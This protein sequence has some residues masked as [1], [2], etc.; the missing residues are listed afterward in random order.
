[1]LKPGGKEVV[2]ANSTLNLLP[3]TCVLKRC[4]SINLNIFGNNKSSD[5]QIIID[6]PLFRVGAQVL[7]YSS[8]IIGASKSANC[9]EDL[10]WIDQPVNG[11]RE[12]SCGAPF[13]LPAVKIKNVK[14]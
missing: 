9:S 3:D 1:M 4:P 14:K 6:D 10:K 5:F 7:L 2:S 13:L 11:S 8:Y 12:I